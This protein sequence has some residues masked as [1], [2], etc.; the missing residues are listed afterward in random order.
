MAGDL[1]IRSGENWSDCCR[2]C[3]EKT[4][5]SQVDLLETAAGG[6]DFFPGERHH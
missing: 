5:P 1:S 3:S 2:G 4:N 6:V